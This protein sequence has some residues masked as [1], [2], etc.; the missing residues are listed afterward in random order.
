MQS[1]W[2]RYDPSQHVG[3]WAWSSDEPPSCSSF[4]RG[5][6]SKAK[7]AVS[8]KFGG[9]FH[10][11]ERDLLFGQS[12]P[13]SMA[14][15]QGMTCHIPHRLKVS[16]Y[17][18]WLESGWEWRAQIPLKTADRAPHGRQWRSC[19][20]LHCSPVKCKEQC[21]QIKKLSYLFC[22]LSV[23]YW[24]MLLLSITSWVTL[25]RSLPLQI[26]VVPV[27]QV[28]QGHHSWHILPAFLL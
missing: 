9:T 23:P 18:V 13:K 19:T 5:P 17:T 14:K 16:W 20:L 3:I 26:P 28:R 11:A 2:R 10:R 27:V 22:G 1:N 4:Y 12:P 15:L 25:V 24:S 7:I 21:K 8:K 6:I